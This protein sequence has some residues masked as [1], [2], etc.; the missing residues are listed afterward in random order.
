MDEL[1]AQGIQFNGPLFDATRKTVNGQQRI[2]IK[3]RAYG[4]GA[5]PNQRL[6]IIKTGS[7]CDSVLLILLDNRT[8]EPREMWEAP[9]T[10]VEERLR[11]P[12]SKSRARGALGVQEF[13]RIAKRIW[14]A[15]HEA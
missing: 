6:G 4:D 1:R 10:A 7:P 11:L 14:P 15:H 5:K 12:G 3:G 2:Q 8:L 13:K 9:M